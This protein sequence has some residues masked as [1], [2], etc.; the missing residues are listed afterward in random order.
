M[1]YMKNLMAGFMLITV[2]AANGSSASPEPFKP[3]AVWPDTDGKHIN[4]HGGGILFHDG[5]YYWFGEFKQGGRRGNQAYDGISCYTSTNLTTWKNEGIALAVE[6]EPASEIVPG[7]IM[8]RPKVIYNKKTGKFVMWFHLELKGKGYDAARTGVAISD[9]VT[10]PYT[11]LRSYRPNAGTWPVN[12]PQPAEGTPGPPEDDYMQYFKRDLA[13]GQM[14][15]DMTL[16][17]DDDGTAY[18][19][20]AAEENYTLH[21][22]R[23]SDDY[24]SF[25]DQWTRVIPGGHNEAPAIFKYNGKYYMITSGCTG[26]DPNAARLHVADSMLGEWTAL[27]NPCIGEDADT[28]FTSQSTFVLPVQGLEGAFI[29]M[30]DRWNPANQIDSRYIWLPIRFKDDVPYLQWSDEWDLGVFQQTGSSAQ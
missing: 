24:T 20:H 12:M 3:G 2:L 11:Y 28:T 5:V 15:R 7:C 26:W 14:S 9:T 6:Q 1:I 29:F 19:V 23:L 25:T 4:A 27:G 18:H 30:A 8:E 21:I 16:F 17:V 13:G 22:S 10:G